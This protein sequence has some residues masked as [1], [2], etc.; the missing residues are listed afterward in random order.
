MMDW[1]FISKPFELES[2]VASR[3]FGSRQ[4]PVGDCL[5]A[6]NRKAALIAVNIEIEVFCRQFVVGSVAA[7]FSDGLI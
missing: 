2:N 3:R 4:C 1:A 5:F 6:A 7:D